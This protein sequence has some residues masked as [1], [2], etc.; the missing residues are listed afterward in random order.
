MEGNKDEA[1]RCLEIASGLITQ[2][3]HA[4]AKRF[5]T[6]AEKLFPTQKAKGKIWIDRQLL[7]LVLRY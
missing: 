2:G 5:I 4:K 6:K 3:E 1:M 7:G